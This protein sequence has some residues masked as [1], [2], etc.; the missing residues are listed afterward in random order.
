VIL[1]VLVPGIAWAIPVV[2][3]MDTPSFVAKATDLLVVRCL[4]PDVKGGGKTDGL[5]LIEVEVLMVLKGER[6]VGKAK[7]ATSGQRME[8]ERRYLLASFG[9]S[10]FDTGFLAQSDQAVVEL[11]PEFDLKSPDFV[12]D[13][14]QYRVQRIFDAR[15][16]QVNR[17]I[18]ELQQEKAVL[19]RTAEHPGAPKN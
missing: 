18:L 8:K 11:P 1:F 10:A 3:T 17:L 19:D 12:T 15:R 16:A 9:G 14:L 6:T 5:T 7:L 13:K 2:P 4:N